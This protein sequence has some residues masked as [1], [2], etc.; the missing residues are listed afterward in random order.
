[1]QI[2]DFV[3][4]YEG[5]PDEEADLLQIIY[6]LL[7]TACHNSV[8]RLCTLIGPRAVR[9]LLGNVNNIGDIGWV[10]ADNSVQY[11]DITHD[12]CE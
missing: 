7:T 1:M 4:A 8:P 12:R 3:K 5:K 9:P 10:S 2:Q 11:R 6:R